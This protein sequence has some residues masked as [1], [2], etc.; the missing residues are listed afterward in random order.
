[1]ITQSSPVLRFPHY[2]QMRPILPLWVG[3]LARAGSIVTVLATCRCCS[4]D[5]SA[6][7]RPLVAPRP[8]RATRW[9]VR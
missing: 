8:G 1:M 4:R 3:H 2:M 7:A 5:G 9:M 6:A